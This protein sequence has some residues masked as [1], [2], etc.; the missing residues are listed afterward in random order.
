MSAAVGRS[1]RYLRWTGVYPHVC[2]ETTS[3][4]SRAHCA[5]GLSLARQSSRMS[6]DNQDG[7]RE[8]YRGRHR[9]LPHGR[10]LVRGADEDQFRRP[11]DRHGVDPLPHPGKAHRASDTGAR[12][13]N[14]RSSSA[15]S[16]MPALRLKSPRAGLSSATGDAHTTL[17][18]PVQDCS[19]RPKDCRGSRDGHCASASSEQMS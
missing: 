14:R 18:W 6:S 17:S 19:I 7:D 3:Y 12:P 2:G 16:S 11:A 8:H 1:F 5:T 13:R 15:S 4:S 9:P 10:A